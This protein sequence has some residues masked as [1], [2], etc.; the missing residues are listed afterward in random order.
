M[1]VFEV[2]LHGVRSLLFSGRVDL[3]LPQHAKSTFPMSTTPSPKGSPYSETSQS[4]FLSPQHREA[5]PDKP[6]LPTGN[7]RDPTEPGLH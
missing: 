1:E 4:L 6:A 2:S 7:E 5:R 3:L